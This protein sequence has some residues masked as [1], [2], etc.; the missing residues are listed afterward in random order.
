MQTL[1]GAFP[2]SEFLDIGFASASLSEVVAALE[3]A[4][5]ETPFAYVVTPNVDH[6]VRLSE[7]GPGPERDVPER[8]Q[9]ADLILCDSR[10]LS[11]LARRRGID[12]PVVPGSDLTPTLLDRAARPGDTINIVGGWAETLPMLAA[13]YPHLHFRQHVP[14]MGLRTNSA[15]MNE[16]ADFVARSPA[17][18]TLLAVGSPQQEML[19]LAIKKRG[20]ARGIGFCVGA[21]INFL[22]GRERRAPRLVQKLA[23]E[24]FYRLA[25]NPARLW[26]RY[27]VEGPKIFR[28]VARWNPTR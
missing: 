14:P 13:K 10:V 20:D 26:R 25:Q 3:A 27:L 8:Y 11:L 9:A 17:R 16:A 7:A 4:D 28:I 19:A 21:S 22:V 23:L 18:F 12:L 1:F 6:M 24:W 15:A 5:T 2:R